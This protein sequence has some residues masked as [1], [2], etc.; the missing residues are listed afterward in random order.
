M[1]KTTDVIWVSVCR[2]GEQHPHSL[3][4]RDTHQR[5]PSLLP[6]PH[7]FTAA[8]SQ[9]AA[10][11]SSRTRLTNA[12]AEHS[13]SRFIVLLHRGRQSQGISPTTNFVV[14]PLPTKESFQRWMFDLHS[15]NKSSCFYTNWCKDIPQNK[16]QT[17]LVCAV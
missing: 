1:F 10:P 17:L 8:F 5:S 2:E 13:S 15:T 9:R 16:K 7:V 11:N 6:L 4:I 3:L 14:A 12:A